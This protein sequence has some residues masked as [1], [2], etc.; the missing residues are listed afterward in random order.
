[1]AD[2]NTIGNISLT[3]KP[4]QSYDA[5]KPLAKSDSASIRKTGTS[6]V[7]GSNS[8]NFS[9]VISETIARQSELN[10]SAHSLK[11]MQSRGITLNL[12]D[13]E[14][15]LKAQ[16]KLAEKGATESLVMLDDKAFVLSVKNKTVITALDK[17]EMKQTVFTNIDSAVIA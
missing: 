4:V 12:N 6:L 13:H 10:F 5:L 3:Y 9:Q 17:S 1:M 2:I 7:N 14:R 16:E 8:K 11:R 15:L